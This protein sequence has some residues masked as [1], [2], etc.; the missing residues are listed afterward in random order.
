[1][2]ISN[3]AK[4]IIAGVIVVIAIILILLLWPRRG[5]VPAPEPS[6]PTAEEVLTPAPTPPAPPP[7]LT[8]AEKAE[9]SAE[10]VG[11]IFV[12]RYGSYSSESDLQN[13]ADV[14][15]LTTGRYRR[16]LENF[17]AETRAAGA[18]S[19]YYGVSTRVISVTT[20]ALDDSAGTATLTIITQRDESR[21]SVRDS[22]VKYQTIILE[23]SQEDGTWK[24]DNATWQTT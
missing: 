5:A 19:T 12:E 15:D 11:K 20:T 3:R 2:T 23:V 14:L 7:V 18:P 17:I 13:I 10:T 24:V 16:V 4:V 21:G 8:P 9:V 22:S 1:M 6:A